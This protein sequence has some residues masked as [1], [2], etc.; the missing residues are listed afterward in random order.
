MNKQEKIKINKVYIDENNKRYIK[1]SD[2]GISNIYMLTSSFKMTTF[3]DDENIYVEL[4]ELINFYKKEIKKDISSI[5]DKNK[6]NGN[7]KFLQ[8]LKDKNFKNEIKKRL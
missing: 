7:I 3:D 6:L 5:E 1:I 4:E 2:T 8:N